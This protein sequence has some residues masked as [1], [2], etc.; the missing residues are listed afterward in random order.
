MSP[1]PS[2][3]TRV[4]LKLTLAVIA[5]AVGIAAAVIALELVRTVV[6]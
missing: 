3:S 2:D 5:L 4:G 1:P 6:S